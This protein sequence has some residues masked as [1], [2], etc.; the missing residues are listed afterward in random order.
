MR[1]QPKQQKGRA[2]HDVA[3][4][5]RVRR[6]RQSPGGARGVDLGRGQIASR[7]Q[8]GLRRQERLLLG[9]ERALVRD[10]APLGLDAAPRVGHRRHRARRFRG[11]VVR[12]IVDEA[13]APRARHDIISERPLATDDV[14]QPVVR[15]G[16][17][18]AGAVGTG[19]GAGA[20][21]G[22][23]EGAA[24]YYIPESSR[25]HSHESRRR[26]RLWYGGLDELKKEN[27]QFEKVAFNDKNKFA[28]TFNEL[29]DGD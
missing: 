24:V 23:C 26:G 21:V 3:A 27:P 6:E 28:V 18:R 2:L 25:G 12:P 19:T 17:L 16:A 15:A 7:R 11:L 13:L 29:A 20:R 1:G 14:V 22:A 10:D 9:D 5:A 4:E 8:L